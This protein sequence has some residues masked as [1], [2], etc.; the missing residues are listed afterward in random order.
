SESR[1]PGEEP[2]WEACGLSHPHSACSSSSRS[3]SSRLRSSLRTKSRVATSLMASRKAATSRARYS[4]SAR[5]R[6]ARCRSCSAATRSRSACRSCASRISGADQEPCRESISDSRVKVNAR[7]SNCQACGARVFQPSQ[8]AQNTVMY[9]R[10]RGVPRNRAI[11][12]ATLPKASLF[13]GRGVRQRRRPGRGVSSRSDTWGPHHL[14]GH[15]VIT[16]TPVRRQQM[17]QH[18]VDAD[19]P[20]QVAVLVDD[21]KCGQVV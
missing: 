10:N 15:V 4:V 21:G 16:L 7:G 18:V 9:S 13:S 11:A 14:V 2:R 5:L 12:S 19:Y 17:V 6:S 3:S 8:T 1:T 20:E